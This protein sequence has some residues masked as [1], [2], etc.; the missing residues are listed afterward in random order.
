MCPQ[1]DPRPPPTVPSPLSTKSILE[2]L[3]PC[4]APSLSPAAETALRRLSADSAASG[5]WAHYAYGCA[6]YR[7]EIWAAV[8]Y[9]MGTHNMSVRYGRPQYIIWARV[10]PFAHDISFAHAIQYLL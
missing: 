4:G 6:R 9:H 7:Y 2:A 10:I 1:I 5:C 8:I 3:R